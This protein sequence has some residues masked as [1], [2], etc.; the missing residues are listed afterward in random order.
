[1]RAL[2]VLAVVLLSACGL[3]RDPEDTLA[4]VRARGEIRVGVTEAPPFIRRTGP[5][6][7]AEAVGVEA[8]LIRAIARAHGLRVQWV[9]GPL[10]EHYTAL[11]KYA[12]D[13]AA[14]AITEETPWKHRLGFTKPYTTIRVTVGVPA[15]HAAVRSL[16]G[17][18]VAVEP[19]RAWQKKLRSHGAD[20]EVSERPFETR[21]A[22]AAPS[23]QLAA[24]GYR[25]VDVDPLDEQK[26]VL[27]VPPGENE[28]LA[29]IESHVLGH[30]EEI[31]AKLVAEARP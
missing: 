23:W 31:V 10:D 5:D 18:Q 17:L 27:V 6:P 28:W 11:G 16:E 19:G 13:L 20:V 29:L 30:E 14:G 26:H 21:G 2:W 9:W 8:D 15:G 7:G 4:Q 24:H 22:V 12:L 1:M 25:A 3:P